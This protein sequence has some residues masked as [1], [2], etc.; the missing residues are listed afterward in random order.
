[1]LKDFGHHR[2]FPLDHIA[3]LVRDCLKIGGQEAT[4]IDG[5]ESLAGRNL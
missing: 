2:F 5:D 1:M 4:A 3:H